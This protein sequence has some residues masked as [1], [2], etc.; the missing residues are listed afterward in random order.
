MHLKITLQ[1]YRK[2]EWPGCHHCHYFAVRNHQ[3][4]CRRP[5]SKPPC[6][7]GHVY[8]KEQKQ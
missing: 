2:G 5:K 4:G 8:K 1:P 3:H 7:A 6:T